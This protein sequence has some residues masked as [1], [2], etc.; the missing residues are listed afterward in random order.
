MNIIC[1]EKKE[2]VYAYVT[3]NG[4]DHRV[5]PDGTVMIWDCEEYGGDYVHMRGHEDGYDEIKA[6]GLRVLNGDK[7]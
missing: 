5:Y 2:I 7:E 1:A 6:A 3:C 4:W